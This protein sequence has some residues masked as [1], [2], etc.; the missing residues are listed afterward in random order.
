MSPASFFIVILSLFLANSAAAQEVTLR[1][2]SNVVLVPVLVKDA[3][4]HAVY[5]LQAQDFVIE[6]DGVAQTVHLDEAAQAEPVS[7]VVAIQCGREA[8]REFPRIRGLSSMI[9]PVLDQAGTLTAVVEFDSGIELSQDFTGDEKLIEN[10]LRTVQS[11]DGGAAILDAVKYSLNLLD[12][13]PA[14]RQRVLLLVSETRDHGSRSARIDDVVTAIGETN[15]T[16]Y[17][18]AFS[19]ALSNVL[20]TG[21]G[22]NRDEMNAGPDLLAPLILARQAMRKNVPKAISSMTGGEYGLFKSQNGFETGMIDFTNHL[23][24]RYLLSFQPRDPRPGL[25]ELRVRLRD[26]G[27]NEILARGSYW[28]SD[29]AR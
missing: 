18:L 6:D 9:Q 23:H 20:D 15:T 8:Y 26:P 4:G 19:P 5:G 24:S 7:L 3:R 16:I 1:A 21:R 10:T 28:A 12:K 11:G 29:A 2:Q 22:N 27:K 25:H 14:E 17:T 13:Q